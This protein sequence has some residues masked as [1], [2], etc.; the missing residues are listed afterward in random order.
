MLD[1]NQKFINTINVYLLYFLF[2]VF[3]IF[4]TFRTSEYFEFNKQYLLFL[5][6]PL[7]I[8]L[9]L[10][11]GIIID[12]KIK[13]KSTPLDVPILT[14][15][16]VYLAAAFF[17]LDKH[18]SFFGYYENISGSFFVTFFLCALYV[19]LNNFNFSF[20]K[21]KFIKALIYSSS[22]L[23]LIY[24]FSFF[25]FINVIFPAL[26]IFLKD[27]VN[28]L[29]G[30]YESLAIY[31]SI[32]IIITFG[33]VYYS[34]PNKKQISNKKELLFFKIFIFLFIFCL[35]AISSITSFII[36]LFGALFYLF[37]EIKIQSI[38]FLKWEEKNLWL[39]LF[40]I[41]SSI[42]LILSS[43]YSFS[44]PNNKDINID[45]GNSYQI[46]LESLKNNPIIGTGPS[47]FAY[48]FSRYRDPSMNYGEAWLY[49][50]DSPASYLLEILISSGFFGLIAY[51]LIISI[52]IDLI[53]I[54][55]EKYIN[56]NNYL[57]VLPNLVAIVLFIILH[58]VINFSLALL[59]LF[60]F[61]AA[62][63]MSDFEEAGMPGY[64]QKIIADENSKKRNFLFL[65]VLIIFWLFFIAKVSKLWLGDY[66]INRGQESDFIKAADLETGSFFHEIK[67][68]KYY[69]NKLKTELAKPV[70]LQDKGLVQE[71]M[72]NSL[73]HAQKARVIQP[74]SVLTHEAVGM[75]YRDIKYL[76]EGGSIEAINAFENAIN[77]EPSNPVLY[78]ELGKEYL[79][80]GLNDKAAICFH[81][82]LELKN[83]FQEAKF[84]LAKVYIAQEKYNSAQIILDELLNIYDDPEIYFEKGRLYY[85]QGKINMAIDN[86]LESI[87][88][89]PGHYEAL[90]G[91]AVAYESIGDAQEAQRYLQKALKINPNLLQNK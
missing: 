6:I 78:A 62:L 49:R 21:Y 46:S 80:I 69:L 45:Y 30:G 13:F 85:N 14:F 58:F 5:I 75:V 33:Y 23:A 51:L 36:L 19:I 90:Y 26:S 34:A 71:S 76:G 22:I 70:S 60:W 64:N 47:A 10:I 41:F 73:R 32:L 72:D 59:F 68:S 83:D 54:Y 77:F 42:F 8:F 9:Y 25:G 88:L 48:N 61:L 66:F 91:L 37:A 12:K 17:S 44:A 27:Y 53:I 57:F 67:I 81:K 1:S 65:F 52:L 29:G 18:S 55:L 82:A 20:Y 84:G 11:K 89:D 4:F 40:V 38:K 56:K 7:I 31:F 86:F 63:L 50:Y 16:F 28:L 87:K 43:V 74:Y 35:A 24:L 2:F 79:Y 39:V 15:L 3:P